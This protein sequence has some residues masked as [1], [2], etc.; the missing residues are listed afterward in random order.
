MSRK[1]KK[2]FKATIRQPAEGLQAIKQGQ[3]FLDKDVFVAAKDLWEAVDLLKQE[4]HV[5]HHLI[6]IKE[7]EEGVYV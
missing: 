7:Q 4:T 2:L 3:D 1:L 6:N 5:D